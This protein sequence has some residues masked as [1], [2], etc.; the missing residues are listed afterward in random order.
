ME[1]PNGEKRVQAGPTGNPGDGGSGVH[2][3]ASGLRAGGVAHLPA[4]WGP[5]GAGYY[6]GGAMAQ[7]GVSRSPVGGSRVPG[8]ERNPRGSGQQL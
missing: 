6:H 3:V 2:G 5:R 4:K 8:V 7:V 1:G